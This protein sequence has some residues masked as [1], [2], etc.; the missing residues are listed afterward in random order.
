MAQQ[1]LDVQLPG[2]VLDR[3]GGKRVAEAVGVDLGDAGPTDRKCGL[4]PGTGCEP[5]MAIKAP[6]VSQMD[7]ELSL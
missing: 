3:P 6:A 7:E 1:V 4:I 5:P 2:L